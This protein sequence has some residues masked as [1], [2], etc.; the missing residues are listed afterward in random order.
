MALRSADVSLEEI[1]MHYP[2]FAHHLGVPLDADKPLLRE[3]TVLDRLYHSV[4]RAGGHRKIAGQ[5]F[6]PL[7]MVRVDLDVLASSDFR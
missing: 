7:V 2:Y 6:D 5:L 4:R 3:V 1:L